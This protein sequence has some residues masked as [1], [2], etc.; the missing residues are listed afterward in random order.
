MVHLV[1]RRGKAALYAL[2]R[3]R[4]LTTAVAQLKHHDVRLLVLTRHD[5]SKPQS[6]E[7]NHRVAW[8]ETRGMIAL[9]GTPAAR[10]DTITP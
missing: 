9:R 7:R 6:E 4:S 2:C 1:I 5:V 10:K 3:K 8:P